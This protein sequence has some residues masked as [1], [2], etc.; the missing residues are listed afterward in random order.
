MQLAADIGDQEGGQEHADA[1][2][3]DLLGAI[4]GEQVKLGGDDAISDDEEDGEGG[5]DGAKEGGEEFGG[6]GWLWVVGEECMYKEGRIAATIEL[7]YMLG[8]R[9][10]YQRFGS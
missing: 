8:W 2:G 1:K 5:L 6:H 7:I 9:R 10:K 3:A 4:A